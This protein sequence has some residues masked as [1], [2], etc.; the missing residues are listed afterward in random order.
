[1]TDVV[2]K[3]GEHM[4]DVGTGNWHE[5]DCGCQWAVG[6]DGEIRV[7]PNDCDHELG[8]VSSFAGTEYEYKL[9]K[10]PKT[11]LRG[12]EYDR[13]VASDNKITSW[14][15]RLILENEY[16]GDNSKREFVKRAVG[17]STIYALDGTPPKGYAIDAKD[18]KVWLYDA[19]G[20]KFAF[21]HRIS[22][23]D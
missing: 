20:N 21:I 19:W 7:N 16:G 11:E 3:T 9:E 6:Y 5:I 10:A 13:Y 22:Q 1:M 17:N 15:L 8:Y 12:R 18:S 14:Q 4:G 2:V 23:I